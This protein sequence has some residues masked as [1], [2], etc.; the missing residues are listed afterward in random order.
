MKLVPEDNGI[1]LNEE[2]TT[3]PCSVVERSSTRICADT[4]VAVVTIASDD[5]AAEDATEEKGT[6]SKQLFQQMSVKILIKIRMNQIIQTMIFASQ[7]QI[8]LR[9]APQ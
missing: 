5:P 6:I 3:I 7:R 2:S 9:Y 4:S 1:Q 8:S